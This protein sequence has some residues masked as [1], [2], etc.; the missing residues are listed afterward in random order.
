MQELNI[1]EIESVSGGVTSAQA[2]AI[3]A[4]VTAV[5]A[6][7]LAAVGSPI[8]VPAAAAYAIVSG[9]FALGAALTDA[10]FGGFLRHSMAR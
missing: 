7:V 4:G 2:L 8:L 3:G 5:G 6:G 10:G 1:A 9:S